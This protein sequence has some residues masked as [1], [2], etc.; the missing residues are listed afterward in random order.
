MVLK[1][2]TTG[3]TLDVKRKGTDPFNFTNYTKLIFI[4]NEMPGIN[5]F[6]DGLGRRL[7]NVP[8]KAKFKPENED[9]NPFITDKFLSNESINMH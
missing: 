9:Y 6:T 8:F 4:A 5:G 2:L 7:H 3:V 1:K